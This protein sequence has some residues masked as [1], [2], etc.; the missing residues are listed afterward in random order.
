VGCDMVSSRAA[1]DLAE[2][3]EGVNAVVGWHPN[4]TA[5]YEKSSLADLRQML[6]HPKVVAMGEIGLDWHWE[7][8]TPEQQKAA[9]LDQLNLAREVA[10]PVVFHCREAYPD[11]L[12]ILEGLPRNPY[13]FH[14]FSGDEVDARRAV[15]LDAYFGVDGPISYKSAG[16]LRDIVRSLPRDRIVVETDSPYLSPMPHRGKPNRPAYV[17]YVNGA[18][19]STLG[20]TAEECAALSTANATRFFRF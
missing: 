16:A 3:Y 2:R 11:L 9:L 6:A 10:V 1:I 14:C 5:K 20:M 17:A 7:Y 15:A 18:L 8:A 19:A 13:L 4:Y 12:A